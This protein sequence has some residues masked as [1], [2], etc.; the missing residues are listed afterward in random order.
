MQTD[1]YN[2]HRNGGLDGNGLAIALGATAAL[3]FGLTLTQPHFTRADDPP[4]IRLTQVYHN[5]LR[6]AAEL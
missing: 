3:L 2:G 4:L 5:L 6:R 1:R